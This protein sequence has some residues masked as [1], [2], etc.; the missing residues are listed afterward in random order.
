LNTPQF[1]DVDGFAGVLG[2]LDEVELRPVAVSVPDGWSE[3]GRFRAVT[4][5]VSGNVYEVLSK[6]YSPIQDRQIAEP[7]YREAVERGLKTIGRV[8]GVGTGKTRG[9]VIFANPEFRIRLLEDYPD[10]VLL[11]VRF[12]NSYTG[13]M[14]FGLEGFGIRQVC[15]N[16]NLWG[17]LIGRVSQRHVAYDAD[18]VVD[19]FHAVIET[20]LDRS[21]VL[22]QIVR[23][24]QA[25][26]VVK[27]DVEDLLWGISLPV[28]GI[29]SITADV[30]GW[31]PEVE[32]LGLTAWSLYNA[33]TAYI[34]W[35]PSGGKYL[36]AT[37]GHS[38][39][40][41]D[42]LLPEQHD[43]LIAKGRERKEAYKEQ[44]AEREKLKVRQ[45]T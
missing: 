25:A 32:R 41:V 12:F 35:R 20:M 3:I 11:G 13:Q 30:A 29:E 19:Q 10:D 36:D 2:D 44:Q 22:T 34:T 45:T 21:P 8:D 42:L 27:T 18:K 16:Y 24:A 6:E 23:K 39:R 4:S 5:K 7:L 9:H 43:K 1:T 31:V 37:E 17:E 14:S 15:I 33:A 38:R 26:I 28:R 40:A